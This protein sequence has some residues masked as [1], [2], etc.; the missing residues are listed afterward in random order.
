MNPARF[1]D[2]VT[3]YA[4]P[5][6]PSPDATGQYDGSRTKIDTVRARVREISGQQAIEADRPEASARFEVEIREHPD[7]DRNTEVDWNDMTL[8]VDQIRRAGRM[9]RRMF[10]ECS[11]TER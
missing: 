6:N 9:N 3:L 5:D 4:P 11:W 7:V 8:K 1:R 10:L 2:Q